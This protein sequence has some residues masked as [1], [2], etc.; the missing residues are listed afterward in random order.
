MQSNTSATAMAPSQ[1]LT[2]TELERAELYIQQCHNGVIGAI[3]GLSESQWTFKPA[4][5]RWSIGQ[6]IEHVIFVQERVA[7]PIQEQ[8]ASA[9]ESPAGRDCQAVDAIVIN[10]FPNRLAKFQAPPI[11]ANPAGAYGLA[12]AADRL[13]ANA[14]RLS[15]CLKSV[16]NLRGHVVP[17]PPLKAVSQG[18][19]EVMDGYQWILAAAAHTER[20][21]KQILEVK[22]ESD[23]P[24]N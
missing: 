22:A 14:A 20:H 5:D 12:E 4:P 10:Q 17:S 13:A 2:T 9:P 16:P 24:A 11:A 6:I 21:T 7:G 18:A 8:L 1:S 23:F 15:G 3:K 19:Y